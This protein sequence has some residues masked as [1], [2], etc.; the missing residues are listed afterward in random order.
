MDPRPVDTGA[1]L[2]SFPVQ[3]EPERIEL[4]ARIGRVLE[5]GSIGGGFTADLRP[6]SDFDPGGTG[7]DTSGECA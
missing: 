2:E 3:S 5:V 1:I 6:T 7:G 4:R